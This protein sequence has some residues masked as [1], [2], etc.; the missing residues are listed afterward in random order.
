MKITIDEQPSAPDIEV[1]IRCPK[2]DREVL[3]MV[4]RLRMHDHKITGYAD[5]QTRIVNVEDIHY[6]E[7]VDGRTF[8]YTDDAVLETR[9]RLYEMEERL[10]NCDFM[11]ISKNC[12]VNFRSITALSPDLNGRIIAT[13]ENGERIVISRQYATHAKRKIGIV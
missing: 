11:R 13:L 2:T 4:T 12:V 1:I 6:I 10:A 9:L 8:F 5:G 7:S 3:D